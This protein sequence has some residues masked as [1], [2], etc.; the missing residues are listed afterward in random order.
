[1]S[2][3]FR[4]EEQALTTRLSAMLK[5]PRIFEMGDD[6]IG[7]LYTCGGCTDQIPTNRARISCRSCLNYHL[8]A[9]CFVI[10][11]FS[12]PHIDRHPTL[13]NKES[14]LVVS[15][16]P[17]PPN[18]P[19]PIQAAE[20]ELDVPVAN[21]GALWSL[22]KAPLEKKSKKG[23][24]DEH[25]KTATPIDL[26]N[27]KVPPTTGDGEAKEAL[28]DPPKTPFTSFPPSPPRSIRRN[29]EP[30]VGSAPSYPQPAE[31]EL[32]FEEDCTPTPNFIAL[33]STIFSHLDPGH[34][35]YL[36]PETYSG[37]LDVQGYKLEGNI[38]KTR[39]N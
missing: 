14:G 24:P 31:W 37:F 18:P 38:C 21:W 8:C 33:M 25:A 22:M 9:N 26:E 6:K 4:R 32:L 19:Q 29:T 27:I 2:T 5:S 11:Q 16:P 12:R 17:S 23:S 15:T 28:L 39:Y 34:T 3:L 13:V 10:K 36:S 20:T 7:D 1:M 30:E 35:G